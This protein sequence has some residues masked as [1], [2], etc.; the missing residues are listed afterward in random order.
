MTR[1]YYEVQRIEALI[2]QILV[3]LCFIVFV[4]PIALVIVGAFLVFW[5]NCVQAIFEVWK[6]LGWV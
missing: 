3:M 1:S 2:A 5:W 4:V 6:A